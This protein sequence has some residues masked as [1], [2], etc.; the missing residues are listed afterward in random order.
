MFVGVSAGQ[1]DA[2]KPGS[3]LWRRI[4]TLR[5]GDSD[6]L[7]PDPRIVNRLDLPDRRQLLEHG[8]LGIDHDVSLDR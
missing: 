6:R 1:P 5:S 4:P 8:V 3:N 2:V 7:T